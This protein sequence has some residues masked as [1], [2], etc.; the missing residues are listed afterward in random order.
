MHALYNGDTGAAEATPNGA[1]TSISVQRAEN[2]A[3]R[4]VLLG[5]A[6]HDES[7][8]TQHAND[9]FSPKG[10]NNYDADGYDYRRP[11]TP[12][13]TLKTLDLAGLDVSQITDMS[14]M[15]ANDKALTSVTGLDT[16][17]FNPTNYSVGHLFAFDKNLKT[18][19]GLNNWDASHFRY[20]DNMFNSDSSLTG[21]IDLSKWNT[22]NVVLANSMFEFTSALTSVGDLSNWRMPNVTDTSFMFVDDNNITSLGDLSNWRLPNVTNTSAMFNEDSNITN[23]GNLDNWGMGKDTDMSG[24]FAMDFLLTNI[25]DIGKWDVSNVTSM[26]SLFL[27]DYSLTTPG[28]LSNWNVGKVTKMGEMFN[29]ITNSSGFGKRVTIN[30]Q[31]YWVGALNSV[32]DLSKWN[33]SGLLQDTFYMFQGSGIKQVNVSGWK[34]APKGTGEYGSSFD[35]TSLQGHD[36]ISDMFADLVNPATIIANDWSTALPLTADDFA[37]DQPLIVISNNLTALNNEKTF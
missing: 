16:W 9:L 15:I 29:V 26:N 14:T 11:L 33:Q 1:A 4:V 27:G 6:G 23:L 24:M 3:D 2:A 21:N 19:D 36:R 31:D 17:Q 12:N 5:Y 25:G 8:T 18:V 35:G 32:G 13:T 34:F 37:G 20:I 30:G 7:S 28:D 22:Q 10:N